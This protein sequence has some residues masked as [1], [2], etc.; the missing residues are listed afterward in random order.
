MPRDKWLSAGGVVLEKLEEPYKVYVIKPSNDYGPWCFPKGRV[1]AGETLQAAALR[2]VSEEAGIT[3]SIVPGADLGVGVGNYSITHYFLMVKIGE[4]GQHDSETEE[5]QLLELSEAQ[6]LLASSGNSRDVG[7][8]EKAVK[9]LD[10]H[11]KKDITKMENCT[12]KS[13]LE[14]I[15]FASAAAGF[16]GKNINVKLRGTKEELSAITTAISTAN[17]F[18]EELNRADATVSSIMQ[19]LSE[20][21]KAAN[22]CRR[23]FGASWLL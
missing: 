18:N 16:V 11:R 9:Y 1:E 8:L 6:K 2:E 22:E 12:K 15:F 21:Q 5:V 10:K 17:C 3:A 13:L 7:I 23:I 14:N 19:K 20:K 4:L